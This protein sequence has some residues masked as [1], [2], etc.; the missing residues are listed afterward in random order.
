MSRVFGKN[1]RR[2]KN[3]APGTGAHVCG[4]KQNK[5]R[6]NFENKK[7]P[8]VRSTNPLQEVNPVGIRRGRKLKIKT[9][10]G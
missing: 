6:K 10:G 5:T 8:A 3:K 4:G 9:P 2:L 1:F 7:P